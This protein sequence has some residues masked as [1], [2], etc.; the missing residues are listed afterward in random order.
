MRLDAPKAAYVK[1]EAPFHSAFCLRPTALR[2]LA[3]QV[4]ALLVALAAKIRL[5]RTLIFIRV[6]I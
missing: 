2:L 4:D 3:M 1:N 5:L 6:Q